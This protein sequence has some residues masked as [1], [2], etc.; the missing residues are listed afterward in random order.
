VI[1]AWRRGAAALCDDVFKLIGMSV[2][3]WGR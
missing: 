3:G 2:M 1:Q